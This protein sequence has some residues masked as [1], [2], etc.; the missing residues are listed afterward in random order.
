MKWLRKLLGIRTPEEDYDAGRAYVD[1]KQASGASRDE[2]KDLWILC[3]GSFDYTC[4]DRGMRSRLSELCIPHPMDFP[5]ELQ[6]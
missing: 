4:F 3:D 6:E 1:R 2:M 5:H